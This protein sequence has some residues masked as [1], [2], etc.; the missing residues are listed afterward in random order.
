MEN[1]KKLFEVGGVII[2]K[3]KVELKKRR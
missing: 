1:K 2:I 3:K